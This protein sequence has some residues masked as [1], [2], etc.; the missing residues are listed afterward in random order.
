MTQ[1]D[2][3]LLISRRK[4]ISSDADRRRLTQRLFKNGQSRDGGN[5]GHLQSGDIDPICSSGVSF[6][7]T[8]TA[9][10]SCT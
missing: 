1:Y 9:P 7:F 4:I 8:Q 10:W 2:T 6:D 5:D 3:P